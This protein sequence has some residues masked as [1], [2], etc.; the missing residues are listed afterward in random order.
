[1]ATNWNQIIQ[2]IQVEVKVKELLQTKT[3]IKK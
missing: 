2:I 3:E 1:M